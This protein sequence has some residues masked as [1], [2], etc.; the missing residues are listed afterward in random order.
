VFSLIIYK[1]F[2]QTKRMAK[3]PTQTSMTKDS[4]LKLTKDALQQLAR[5]AKVAFTGKSTKE[6][7]ATAI[8]SSGSEKKA[9]VASPDRQSSGEY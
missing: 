2:K 1:Q 4:L 8:V 9:V 3:K 6:Q 7:L 5:K